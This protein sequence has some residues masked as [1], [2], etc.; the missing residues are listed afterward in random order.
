MK[1]SLTIV[2]VFFV[3]IGLIAL[4]RYSRKV[5]K[6]ISK[7]SKN[8]RN[9]LIKTIN[10]DYPTAKK[11]WLIGGSFTTFPDWPIYVLLLGVVLFILVSILSG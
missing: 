9:D 2:V 11:N 10:S 5:N 1:E 8:E 7:L 6:S 4:S 3:L